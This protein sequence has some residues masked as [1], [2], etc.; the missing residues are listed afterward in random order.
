MGSVVGHDSATVEAPQ[1]F[2]EVGQPFRAW[3][4][5]DKS[6]RWEGDVTRLTRAG[7]GST[8]TSLRGEA[9]DGWRRFTGCRG[10]RNYSATMMGRVRVFGRI[11]SQCECQRVSCR[12]RWCRRGR[13]CWLTTSLGSRLSRASAI[14]AAILVRRDIGHSRAL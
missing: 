14:V 7:G 10:I 1:S 3:I 5:S 12:S 6:C 13:G 11:R 9:C 2:G 4:N 8:L